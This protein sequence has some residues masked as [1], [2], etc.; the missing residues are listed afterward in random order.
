MPA[1]IEQWRTTSD[2]WIYPANYAEAVDANKYT[3]AIAKVYGMSDVAQ[4]RA[5]L[6]AAAPELL[7][8]LQATL[9]PLILLGDF[10]G[11][12][13]SGSAG[14]EPFNR[15]EIILNAINAIARATGQE[16]TQ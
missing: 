1:P 14:I 4:R 12:E 3:Q 5:A 11:N 15:C 9:S 13:F 8:A 10:I 7:A 2:G 16:A 6:I